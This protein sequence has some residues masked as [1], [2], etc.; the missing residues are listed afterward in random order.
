M[1]KRLV[2]I[3][4]ND[5][6][7]K[8]LFDLLVEQG[9]DVVVYKSE[10][11][12][13]NK[14]PDV[15]MDVIICNYEL[16]NIDGESFYTTVC[17]E[18]PDLPIIFI[19][20]TKDESTIASMLQYV[21]CEFMVKPVVPA[22]LLARIKVLTTP[23]KEDCE[24]GTDILIHDL[25]LD[26]QGKT[27]KRGKKDIVLTPTEFKLLEYLMSNKNIVLSRDSIL[28]KVWGT[29]ADIS[30]R[31]VDVYIGYLREKVDDGFD[32]KLIETVTGFGYKISG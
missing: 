13:L 5:S 23:E 21:S 31:I 32:H 14:I 15:R 27:A 8:F 17:E 4:N 30:D 10:L 2:L 19:S 24:D 20:S 1:A 29:T 28:N 26:L 16:Q 7:R 25:R 12:L 9:Y 22:E 18:Y 11:E 3:D 6:Y